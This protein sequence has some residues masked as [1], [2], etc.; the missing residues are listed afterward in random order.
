MGPEDALGRY[1]LYAILDKKEGGRGL[2]FQRKSRQ[3][4]GG[5]ERTTHNKQILA[6]LWEIM[7]HRGKY[8]WALLESSVCHI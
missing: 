2:R 3:L 1:G 6:G 4:A 5:L 8:T 7:G